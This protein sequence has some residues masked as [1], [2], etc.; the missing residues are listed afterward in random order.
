MGRRGALLALLAA[1]LVAETAEGIF[2]V[3]VEWVGYESTGSSLGYGLTLAFEILP[4]TATSVVAGWAVDRLGSARAALLGLASASA[5]AAAS[6]WALGLG[7]LGA[8]ASA[9]AASQPLDLWSYGLEATLPVVSGGAGPALQTL[10]SRISLAGSVGNGVG[11]GL[12]GRVVGRA[13]ATWAAGAASVSFALAAGL[14][15]RSCLTPSAW[16]PGGRGEAVAAASQWEGF[17]SVLSPRI[18]PL[19]AY[20]LV[21]NLLFGLG[22]ALWAPILASKGPGA[23]GDLFLSMSLASTG[24][25]LVMERVDTSR[26]TGAFI[27]GA[28]GLQGLVTSL[29]P[30]FPSPYL[31][32]A[33]FGSLGAA[34]WVAWRSYLLAVI[35]EGSRGRGLA[36]V[37]SIL[38]VTLSA[39]AVVGG[40]LGDHL[41]VLETA[42]LSG[43]SLAAVSA[44]TALTWV[45]RL[46]W[47]R[48]SGPE[49]S[50]GPEDLGGGRS[51]REEPAV[52]RDDRSGYQGPPPPPQG[53]ELG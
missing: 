46:G 25:Y 13:G 35:P 47:A 45:G 49:S 40:W 34:L 26:R 38:S 14:A 7:S 2:Y 12:G 5:V 9:V 21:G 28:F 29:F 18:A 16:G 23:Y 37:D 42:T 22:R 36:L 41:G 19:V 32:G 6:A 24:T 33:L 17:S 15:L 8:W 1:T 43:L 10:V 52:H 51:G 4:F 39:G 50:R 11:Y 30:R 20:G 48:A 44:A 53:D 27:A 31:V 3:A